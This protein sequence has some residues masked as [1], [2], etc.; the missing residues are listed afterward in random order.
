MEGK[1]SYVEAGFDATSATSDQTVSYHNLA[2]DLSA[3]NRKNFEMTNRKGVPLVYHCKLTLYRNVTTDRVSHLNHAV[4]VTAPQNWVFRNGAVKLHAGREKMF[5]NAGIKKSDRGRYDKTIRYVWSAHN[6]TWQLPVFSD[7]NTTF[8]DIGEWDPSV[9]AID[10]D[11]D[12]KVA[13]FGTVMDETS[14]VAGTSFNMPNA[15]LNSRRKI[16]LDDLPAAHGAADHSLVRSMFNVEDTADDELQVIADDNQDL[17]PYDQ[18]A[19]AGSFTSAVSSEF[20]VTGSMGAP[21]DIIHFDCPFGI[22][23][24]QMA[25]SADSLGNLSADVF[26][27]IEVL[28]ISEMQG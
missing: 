3:L 27:Q 20:A 5:R 23:A 2:R 15:Y 7:G 17:P 28:G 13:L 12:M 1:L 9:I 26:Y 4:V 8:T 16:D 11:T 6:Q 14:A 19:A 21:K 25:K 24:I 22:C 18:D 10:T